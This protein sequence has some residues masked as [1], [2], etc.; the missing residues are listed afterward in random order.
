MNLLSP[1]RR[2]YI[3]AADDDHYPE[4]AAKLRELALLTRSPGIRRELIDTDRRG[5]HRDR[6]SRREI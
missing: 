4:M 3:S 6:R 1:P 5:D 2:F